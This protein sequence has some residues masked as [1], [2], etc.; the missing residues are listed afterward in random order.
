[1]CALDLYIKQPGTK[2]CLMNLELSMVHKLIEQ[3]TLQLILKSV[4]KME[5]RARDF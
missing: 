3:L 2:S 1:M 4:K 5:L